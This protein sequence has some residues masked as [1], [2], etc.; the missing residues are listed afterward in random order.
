LN[1]HGKK[2]TRQGL[3]KNMKKIYL[4]AGITKDV[5]PQTMRNSFAAHL[6]ANGADIRVVQELMGHQSIK[7]TQSYLSPTKSGVTETYQ[8]YFPR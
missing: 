6:L 3:W 7:T 8:Q 4:Q 5:T 2:L 1:H